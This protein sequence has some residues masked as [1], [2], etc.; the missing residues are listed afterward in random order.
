[1]R[2]TFDLD[3]VIFD[4]NALMKIAFQERGQKYVY[5]K[6]WDMNRCYSPEIAARMYELFQDDRLYQTPLLDTKMPYILNSLMQRPGWEVL[7]VTERV[8]KQPEKS[9]MQLKNAGINCTYEQIYDQIGFKSDILKDIKPDIH[10]DDSPVV[11]KGCLKK[12][13]PVVMISNKTTPY[14]YYLRNQ[15]EHYSSLRKALLHTGIYPDSIK[16]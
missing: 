2:I 5:P 16:R 7:F 15:V 10:F 6:S 14:N 13:V 4:L 12:N 8:L 11:V 3:S 1:M 9:Y